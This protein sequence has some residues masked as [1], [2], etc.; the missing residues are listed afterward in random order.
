MP[1]PDP[2]EQRVRREARDAMLEAQRLELEREEAEQA[3][4]G[5]R[6]R[7]GHE[8]VENDPHPTGF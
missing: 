5:R 7:R 6:G 1:V 8:D 3:A 2:E 4:H